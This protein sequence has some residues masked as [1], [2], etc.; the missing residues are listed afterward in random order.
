MVRG[1]GAR[2]MSEYEAR[3]ASASASGDGLDFHASP[4][5]AVP[6]LLEAEYRRLKT[7][8]GIAE[9]ACGDGALVLPLRHAGFKVTA[10]DVVMR[11]CP[12]ATAADFFGCGVPDG[13]FRLAHVTNPPF[14]RAVEWVYRSCKYFDYVALLLR[15][16]FL[17]GKHAREFAAPNDDGSFPLSRKGQPLWAAT[18]IPLA[19]IIVPDGRFPMMHRGDY[20]GRRTDSSTIDFNW[21]VWD[22]AHHGAPRVIF[23]AGWRSA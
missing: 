13:A 12:E 1:V 11:G 5:E 17:N 4:A 14:N 16:R 23:P 6:A 20:E 7:F 19:R 9:P 22:A 15:A 10:H 2:K 21:Y 3:D 8:P 18:R